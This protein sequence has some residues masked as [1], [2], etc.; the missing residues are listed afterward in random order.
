[1]NRLM[2]SKNPIFHQNEISTHQTLIPHL[3]PSSV[4]NFQ[5]TDS[6]SITKLAAGNQDFFHPSG[7]PSLEFFLPEG[8]LLIHYAFLISGFFSISRNNSTLWVPAICLIICYNRSLSRFCFCFDRNYVLQETHL[9]SLCSCFLRG[10][11]SLV[12]SGARENTGSLHGLS[13]SLS[14]AL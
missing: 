6:L 5:Q 1:M 4:S 7:L 8:T 2:I 12:S 11:T 13:L 3:F 10:H 14:L 9:L